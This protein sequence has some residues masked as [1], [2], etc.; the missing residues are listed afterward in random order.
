MAWLHH[1]FQRIFL[2]FLGINIFGLWLIGYVQLHRLSS[3]A[4]QQANDSSFV[5]LAAEQ[6]AQS[7]II[8]HMQDVVASLSAQV[9][10]TGKQP[11]SVIKSGGTTTQ[12]MVGLK[13]QSIY[14]GS[15]SSTKTDWTDL[16]ATIF[17]LNTTNYPGLEGASFEA[18]LSVVGG[19]ASARVRNKTTDQ[20]ITASEV[21]HNT[22]VS[23]QKLSGSFTLTGGSNVYVV[24]LRSSSNETA[25]LHSARLKLLYR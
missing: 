22:S 17:E 25:V 9:T 7:R 11:A 20:I 21:S 10:A 14:I 19:E 15:G 8:Q 5:D 2:T 3:F 23:T 4:V 1:H 12:A 24:Q 6:T 16:D 13:E 18:T